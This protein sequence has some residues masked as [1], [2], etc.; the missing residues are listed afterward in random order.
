MMDFTWFVLGVLSISSGVAARKLSRQYRLTWIALSGLVFGVLLILFSIAWG[1]GAVLE[2]V[3]R[4]ASM[5][6]LFFGLPGIV[7]LTLT[8]RFI[9]AKLTRVPSGG[10]VSDGKEPKEKPTPAPVPVVARGKA[11]G[12]GAIRRLM[13]YA[14]WLSL[15]IAFVVGAV[16]SGEDYESMVRAHFEGEILVKVNDDPLVLRLGDPGE[17]PGNWILVQEGQGYGGP[18]VLGIRIMEDT[19]VHEIIPLDDKETPA[20]VK[21]VRD[22]DYKYQFAGKHVADDFIVGRDIQAV[23]G[24]TITTMAATEAIRRG[25]HLAAVEKF[26]LE[27]TWSKVPWQIGLKEILVLAV[28]A[29]AFV[30]GMTSGKL[31]K[32]IFLGAAVGVIGFYANASVSIGSIAALLMGFLPGVRDHLTWWILVVGT[33]VTI[34]VLG[35]NVYCTGICPFHGVEFLL[36]KISGSKTNPSR[37]VMKRARLTVN[38]LLWASLMTIF[39]SRLPAAGAYEPFAM[40][41][42]LEGV[43]IQWYILPLALIG[44]FFMSNFWCRFFCPAGHAFTTLVKLRARAL[45]V[46][47]GRKAAEGT[48]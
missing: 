36:R 29:L 41:F 44:S 46:L 37:S 8:L 5:G 39:L 11:T 18:F 33:V 31:R 4:A 15:I 19:T 25:A 12:A 6:I 14:A 43:G 22:S 34:V 40:M 17:G 2:G 10:E 42:S 47:R 3:P 48:Q 32:Y 13:P 28:F 7:L 38:C 20:F 9:T 35:R 45:S 27:P 1:M 16:S 21:K 30:P 23:T 24:A 26:G